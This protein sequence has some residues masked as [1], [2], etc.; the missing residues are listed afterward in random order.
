MPN[1]GNDYIDHLGKLWQFRKE[2]GKNISKEE[3]RTKFGTKFGFNKID[4]NKTTL[5]LYCLKKGSNWKCHYAGVY[6]QT[7]GCLYTRGKH[8][9]VTEDKST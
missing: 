7:N 6:L 3:F 1:V 8:E 2:I 9:H 4:K 5:N